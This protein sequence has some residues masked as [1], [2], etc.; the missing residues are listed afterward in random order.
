[1]RRL[2]L[3]ISFAVAATAACKDRPSTAASGSATAAPA[4][5]TA[6]AHPLLWRADKDGKTTY[7]LGT[8]HVGIDAEAQLP[9]QVW[10]KLD[11]A[12]AFAMEANLED[13]AIAAAMQPTSGSL[14]ADLGEAYWKKL[15]D[16][17][18]PAMA[19]AVDHLPAM[20]PAAALSMRGLPPTPPMDK[21][22]AA[23]ASG[24]HKP[25]VYLEPA[26]RQLAVLGKWMDVKAL[27]LMLDQLPVG[28]RRLRQMVAAYRAGDEGTLLAISA[29]EKADALQH[30][31]TAAEYDREMAD[32]LYDRNASWIAEL[33][34]LHAAGGAF[35]AV[36]ALHLVGPG[37]VLDLLA[38]RGFR[39]A[40]VD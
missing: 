9:T 25:I 21:A 22:L 38:R 28:E 8:M 27:R 39:V 35:V 15:E 18:G 26:A 19:S 34:R 2:A 30:G 4:S 16:A 3:V 31:Y 7:F 12:P 37:S 29:D 17:M 10:S 20:V 36:G 40:R 5:T 13:P 24:E 1:M 11:A 32:L 23:R 33:E 14:R 6:I